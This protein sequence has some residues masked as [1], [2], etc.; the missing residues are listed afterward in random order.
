MLKPGIIDATSQR[1]PLKMASLGVE[2]VAP[3]PAGARKRGYTVAGVTLVTD[4]P[5]EV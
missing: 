5:A 3:R 4:D 1:Y 2:K